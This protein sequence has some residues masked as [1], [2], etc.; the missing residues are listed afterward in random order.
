MV[1]KTSP[2][3]LGLRF[4]HLIVPFVG[5]FCML[6]LHGQNPVVGPRPLLLT[7]VVLDKAWSDNIDDDILIV[8][9]TKLGDTLRMKSHRGLFSLDLTQ[10]SAATDSVTLLIA[11]QDVEDRLGRRR[12]GELRQRLLAGNAQNVSLSIAFWY[13]PAL[14][15]DESANPKFRAMEPLH[16]PLIRN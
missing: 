16:P 12:Y 8:V 2:Y 5:I 14:K 3:F 7:G 10:Y 4:R 9:L 13:D 6:S 11:S 1:A 15:E